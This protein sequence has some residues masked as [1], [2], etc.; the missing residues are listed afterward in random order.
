V[1]KNYQGPVPADHLLISEVYYSTIPQNEWVEIHNPTLQPVDLAAYK[2]GDATH[3]EDNEGMYRFPPGTTIPPQG[4][5]V[6]AVTAAGFEEEFP[7]L[8]PDFEIFDSDASVPDL[9]AY[10]AWGQWDW[11]LSNEGD[12]V[13]LLGG[14]DQPVDAVAYGSGS[15]PGL[16]PHP[17][18][19]SYGHSLE[20]LPISLDTDD[21]SL[22]FRDWP[23]PSPGQPPG[24]GSQ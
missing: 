5:L 9:L 13:L 18:G 10:P 3:S 4:I 11:G 8:S 16:V 6:V 22:D 14:Q 2:I 19:L 1:A 7:T 23:F 15:Y 12:E 21:C 17:G 20:R 24:A